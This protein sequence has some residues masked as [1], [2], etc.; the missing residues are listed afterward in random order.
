MSRNTVDEATLWHGTTPEQRSFL[1]QVLHWFHF[2][3]RALK[4]A[5]MLE[6]PL[7][8]ELYRALDLLPRTLFVNPLLS[9]LGELDLAVEAAVAPLLSCQDLVITPYPSLGLTGAKSNCRSDLGFGIGSSPRLWIEAKTAPFRN[10]DIL[11]QLRAQQLALQS[12]S[13]SE[14]IAVV[15]L[16]PSKSILRDWPSLPWR[17]LAESLEFGLVR[18]RGAIAEAELR[19]G[20]ERLA[21][22]MIGRSKSHPKRIAAEPAIAP[23]GT[24]AGTA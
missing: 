15:A 14:K 12:L 20:Y 8:W 11:E 1:G 24:A 23:D 10:L 2:R 6:E 21:T 18:L 13:P 9:Q 16:V 22:E 3:P 7:T 17:A 19:S 4:G 5:W